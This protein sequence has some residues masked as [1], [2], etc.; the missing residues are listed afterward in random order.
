MPVLGG[1]SECFICADA[2]YLRNHLNVIFGCNL[3][4]LRFVVRFAQKRADQTPGKHHRAN[5]TDEVD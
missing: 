2:G 5:S 1:F 4:G 3:G